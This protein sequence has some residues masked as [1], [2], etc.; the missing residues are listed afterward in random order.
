[1]PRPG[2]KPLL[3]I[4]LSALLLL[5]PQATAEA[6]P[7]WMN[8]STDVTDTLRITPPS[9]GLLQEVAPPGPTQEIK[10]RLSNH[11]PQLQLLSPKANSVNNATGLTLSLKV[12]DWPVSRDPELGLGPHVALQVDDRPL[13]R[14]D[15]LENGRAEVQLDDLGPGSH[16]FAAWAAYPWGEAVKSTGASLQWRLHQWQRLEGTQPGEDEP[17]LVANPMVGGVNR[18]P[19]L[20]DWQLWNAP[21]QNLRDGDARWRV[22][23]SLDGDS[24]LVDH[25]D[26]L[27][28]KGSGSNGGASVQ[29]ELLDGRGEPLQPAFNNRLI[30]LEP[31]ADAR[32]VWL[33]ERIQD[34]ELLR[35]S[36]EPVPAA[37][38]QETNDADATPTESISA[39]AAP[40]LNTQTPANAQ[41]E[42]ED[43]DNA[44]GV[45]PQP[46]QD[47]T[48]DAG[49]QQPSE[50]QAAEEEVEEEPSDGQPT[51]TTASAAPPRPMND[52][53]VLRPEASLGGSARELLDAD[54]RLRQP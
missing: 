49:Q 41:P 45:E 5:S 4:L 3:G 52:P 13:L 54:G 34:E 39:P 44:E 26:A 31:A 23:I 14:I 50:T 25:Q 18:Q 15:T 2:L 22:R 9:S 21:L 16:R 8:R 7:G 32:P 40:S 48:R 17:W 28:L 11:R 46:S 30:R 37:D 10:R 53:S 1:M 47:I 24:F 6:R 35:L 19:L 20:L 29:M 27:W 51:A 12:E 33:K 38:E 42:E 43:D 36:G